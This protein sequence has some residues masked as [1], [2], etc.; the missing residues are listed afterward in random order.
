MPLR[1][2]VQHLFKIVLP[3]RTPRHVLLAQFLR[4]ATDLRKTLLR[5]RHPRAGINRVAQFLLRKLLAGDVDDAEPIELLLISAVLADVYLQGVVKETR[6]LVCRQIFETA[7][8]TVKDNKEF[9][10]PENANSVCEI[11]LPPQQVAISFFNPHEL[12]FIAKN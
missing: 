11:W 4:H 7:Q 1:N 10:L 9:A 12:N 5:I 2:P 8:R 3:N 6:L